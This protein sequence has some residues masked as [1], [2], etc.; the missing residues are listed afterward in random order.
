M[1]TLPTEISLLEELVATP[2]VSGSEEAVARV[3]EAAARAWGLDVVRDETGVRI[4]LKGKR[5]GATLALVSHLDVVP[6]GEGWTRDPFTP[7]I[8]GGLLFGRGSGDAKASVAAMMTAVRDIA[9]NGGVER[10]RLLVILGFGEETRN[11]TMPEAVRAAGA[12][13]AAIIG[14]PTSLDLAIAQR[15]LMMIDLVARGTQRH[16]A[17]AAEDGEFTN[18][19]EVLA[20]DLTVLGSLCRDKPHPV[21]GHPTITPTMVNAGVSRNVTPPTAT[22]IL[23][24][25]STPAWSHEELAERI[26]AA[27][28]AEVKV[29]SS[30][31]VPCETPGGSRLLKL[32]S[33]IRRQATHYGSPTCSDDPRL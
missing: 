13:D 22:A 31:L 16:A 7:S 21:L 30:R 32:A 5:A 4:E 3:V 17:Y 26:R 15:G 6:P 2:S 33:S 24:V 25:R 29:T 12:I 20:K 18:A 14:E 23:D 27:V 1:L 11:T 19:L 10:G 28:R 9:K 8:E